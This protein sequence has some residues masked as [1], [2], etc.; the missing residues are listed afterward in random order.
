MPDIEKV[1]RGWKRCKTCNM[2]IIESNDSYRDCEYTIGLYC[3]RDKLINET[4]ALLEEQHRVE[5][6]GKLYSVSP[7]VAI[8]QRNGLE[9]K[10]YQD[11]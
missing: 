1:I 10:L 3:G 9:N 6:Y 11:I 7:R 5:T 4:I 2:S 8:D